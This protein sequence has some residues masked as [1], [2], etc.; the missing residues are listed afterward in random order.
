ME[1]IHK[2]FNAHYNGL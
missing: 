2:D 1:L